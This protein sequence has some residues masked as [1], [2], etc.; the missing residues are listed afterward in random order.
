[1]R[2]LLR[3]GADLGVEMVVF[4]MPHRGRLNVL[5]NVLSKPVELIFNEFQSN[6]GP[7]D[8]VKGGPERL[9]QTVGGDSDTLRLRCSPA[10]RVS[11]TCLFAPA[12][13]R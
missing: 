8:E 4:G 11:S 12:G 5:A 6:L 10:H 9:A 13:V 3:R 7:D 2:Q 1:M